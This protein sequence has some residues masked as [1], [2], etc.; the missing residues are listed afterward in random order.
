MG[1]LFASESFA[2]ALFHCFHEH[3]SYGEVKVL[4]EGLEQ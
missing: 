3:F 1:N 4:R 2:L